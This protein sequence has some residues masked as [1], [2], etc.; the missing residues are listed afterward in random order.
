MSAPDD[1]NNSELITV[2]RAALMELYTYNWRRSM[3]TLYAP[4]PCA[5][6]TMEGLAKQLC[7]AGVDVDSLQ[8]EATPSDVWSVDHDEAG[9]Q[10]LTAQRVKRSRRGRSPYPW[11]EPL[12]PP[13]IFTGD[14]TAL[15]GD[16]NVGD[17]VAT[18]AACTR[19]P[20]EPGEGEFYYI[21]V[22]TELIAQ[23]IDY[24]GEPKWLVRYLL[25]SEVLHDAE[26]VYD[27]VPKDWPPFWVANPDAVPERPPFT[28]RHKCR[29]NVFELS[30]Q[31]LMSFSRARELAISRYCPDHLAKCKRPRKEP[32]SAHAST[33]QG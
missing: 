30:K 19:M 17:L 22:V 26:K 28:S 3:S 12:E 29:C 13:K 32:T 27:E 16:H 25:D 20:D 14:A 33:S 18:D 2:N 8:V 1:S 9:R 7:S 21:L 24:N 10:K 4:N 5:L 15:W 11:A 23:L 31:D 6:H